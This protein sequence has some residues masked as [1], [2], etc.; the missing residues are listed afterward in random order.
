LD[1]SA[2]KLKK[3]ATAILGAKSRTTILK[4]A[5]P[6]YPCKIP[7]INIWHIYNEIRLFSCLASYGSRR[8]GGLQGN[9]LFIRQFQIS[10]LLMKYLL[11]KYLFVNSRLFS[12]LPRNISQVPEF[13]T[14][15]TLQNTD[16][17]KSIFF[18]SGL[19]TSNSTQLSISNQ[20]MNYI[21]GTTCCGSERYSDI[22]WLRRLLSKRSHFGFFLRCPTLKAFTY[23]RSLFFWPAG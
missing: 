19:Y 4:T 12:L 20:N 10:L 9:R 13:Q 7:V 15:Y 3:R 5:S 8:L 21:I 22:D 11:V 6:F 16:P 14:D 17:A 18:H 1:A 23:I 2:A